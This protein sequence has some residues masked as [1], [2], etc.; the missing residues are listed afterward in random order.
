MTDRAKSLRAVWLS[1]E[2]PKSGIDPL[3]LQ[4]LEPN[5]P[6]PRLRRLLLDELVRPTK[7][8][9]VVLEYLALDKS[10]EDTEG[11]LPLLLVAPKSGKADPWRDMLLVPGGDCPIAILVKTRDLGPVALVHEAFASLAAPH[12]ALVRRYAALAARDRGADR[13]AA[14]LGGG[15]DGRRHLAQLISEARRQITSV[16]DPSVLVSPDGAIRVQVGSLSETTR[17]LLREGLRGEYV[18]ILPHLLFEG[19]TNYA[20]IEFLI[21]L[22]FFVRQGQATRIVGTPRQRRTLQRLLTLVIFGIFDPDADAPASFEQLRASYGI[23]DR[24]TYAFLRMAHETYAART[25]DDPSSPIAGLASYVDFTTLEPGGTTVPIHR[26]DPAGIRTDLGHVHITGAPE[27]FDVR[28]T[29]GDGRVAAKRMEVTIRRRPLLAVPEEAAHHV[30]FGTNRPRFGVTPLGTSHGFDPVGDVTSFVV[31]VNGLG[32]LVDPSPESLGYLRRIG[33]ADVDVPFVFLTHIHAD[34][35]GGLIEKILSGSRTTVIA[36]DVVFRTFIE[37]AH[38]VT[39]H[40]V[41]R[42]GLVSHVP[43]NPGQ[44]IA[45]DMAGEQAIL[46]SRWNLHPIPTNGFTLSVRGQSFGY[47]GDTQYDPAF[48]N[49]LYEAGRLTSRQ[50]HE[51]LHF[52]WTPDGTPTVDLLFHEAGIP[53]IHTD[54]QHLGALP[55]AVGKRT[56]LV[57]IADAD[58]PRDFVPAKPALFTT[59]VLLPPD[60]DVRRQTLRN[61]MR[62]VSYLYDV[63]ADVIDELLAG[64]TVREYEADAEILRKGPVRDDTPLSFYVIVDGEVAVRD[65]RRLIGTLRKGD[66]FGEWGISHQRGFRTAD[67]ITTRRSQC[68]EFSEA[69]YRWLIAQCPVIQERMVVIRRLLPLLETAQARARV[70]AEVAPTA[71]RSVMTAMSTSQ[72]ASFAL[73]STVRTFKEGEAV[74]VEGDEADGFYILLSGYLIVAMDGRVVGE[75]AEGEIFGELG[76]LE[77][78]RRTATVTT[79]SADAEVLFMKTGQFQDLLHAVPAF[80]AQVHETASHR[81]VRSHGHAPAGG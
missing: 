5:L 49:A 44:P 6:N 47:S 31:W 34:H 66:S 38:L 12:K 37:K 81:V 72:L 77:G 58:V 52:F 70:K 23:A 62:L 73:F 18:F 61:T 39:G 63:P 69:Q 20:D 41:Q 55:A 56:F 7:P 51:L 13:I 35:D 29:Q 48:V 40:D 28:I 80:A 71:R 15:R 45:I 22:N 17:N 9:D 65:G 43:A 60:A 46:E 78:T 27:G 14:T 59:H 33:V 79:V 21:Y 30:R 67:V 4:L 36:S 19:R 26:I 1:A 24:D 25:S 10:G 74:I 57:H 68:M 50:H 53:P 11:D 8:A 54:K 75:V 16:L 2:P 3:V 32:M 42:E 64:G 76:P